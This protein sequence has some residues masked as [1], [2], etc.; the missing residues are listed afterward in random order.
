MP[1][2]KPILY[3]S[4]ALEGAILTMTPDGPVSTEKGTHRLVDRDIGLECEDANIIGQRVWHGDL[5]LNPRPTDTWIFVGSGYAGKLVTLESSPDNS[6]WTPRASVTP[7]SD[8][9]QRIPLGTT[10]TFRYWRMHL[11]SPSV[12][13]RITEW[14]LS[15]GVTLKF[16][17]SAPNLREGA[18]PQVTM[19]SSGTGRSWGVKKGARRWAHSYVMAYS[20]DVDRLQI[21]S[22]LT[23]VEDGAKPCWLLTAT[24]ETRWVRVPGSINFSAADMSI[25]EWDIPIDPVEELA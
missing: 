4:N 10:F 14:T 19:I 13:V 24:G 11:T 16:K 8:A 20:P 5:G 15:L 3:P 17:P 21:L 7:A 23:E 2:T 12:P 1:A 25:A 18:I 9:V 22:M 6:V